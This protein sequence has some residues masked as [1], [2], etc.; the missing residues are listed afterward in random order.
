MHDSVVRKITRGLEI[1]NKH[2]SLGKGYGP[3]V[4]SC[5]RTLLECLMKVAGRRCHQCPRSPSSRAHGLVRVL[6]RLKNIL[7]IMTS[8][9]RRH[10][11]ICQSAFCSSFLFST[12]F[13]APTPQTAVAPVARSPLPTS[14]PSKYGIY[15]D[16]NLCNTSKI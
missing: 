11:P 5:S 2:V 7:N 3:F 4:L 12:V 14:T 6:L 1:L 10:V 16:T 8:Q 13:A 9:L 15:L